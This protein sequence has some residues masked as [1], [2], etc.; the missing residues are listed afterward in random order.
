[1]RQNV[2][3]MI[4]SLLILS[5]MLFACS[6]G[7]DQV[8]GNGGNPGGNTDGNGPALEAGDFKLKVT[9][10]G[11][12]HVE[13]SWEAIQG[14]ERY[15]VFYS[16][17][18][19]GKFWYAD[20]SYSTSAV[21]TKL[22]PLKQYYFKVG[23]EYDKPTV[24]NSNVVGAV[25][26]RGS[27]E[28]PVNISSTAGEFTAELSWDEVPG[29]TTYIIYRMDIDNGERYLSYTNS[30]PYY[31]HYCLDSGTRYSYLV[32]AYNENDYRTSSPGA[33]HEILTKP[34][35]LTLPQIT[36]EVNSYE[37]QWSVEGPLN[38][39]NRFYLTKDNNVLIFNGSTSVSTPDDLNDKRATPGTTYYYKYRRYGGPTGKE[40]SPF[41]PLITITVPEP[42]LTDVVQN[43]KLDNIVYNPVSNP[44]GYDTDVTISWDPV[45]GAEEYYIYFG[46]K[47]NFFQHKVTETSFSHKFSVTSTSSTELYENIKVRVVKPSTKQAGP[48]SAPLKVKVK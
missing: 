35:T 39:L 12:G 37:I 42:E 27:L 21:V 5:A 46:D 38:S 29:A 34:A 14:V 40:S 10:V 6:T 32:A 48:F 2:F 7:V 36:Y 22:L 19:D 43:L 20:T 1:M 9:A 28:A 26:K 31:D 44:D 13:L 16:T 25:T 24:K 4:V 23:C 17:S 41:G 18:V 45:P 15:I 8:G 30:L 33:L 47:Y 11:E 3:K